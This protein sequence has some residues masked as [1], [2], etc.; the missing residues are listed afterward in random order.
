[1]RDRT[2][3]P[4]GGEWEPIKISSE[5]DPS[6]YI[7]KI[8]TNPQT[9]SISTVLL[10]TAIGTKNTHTVTPENTN[11]SSIEK[12]SNRISLVQTCKRKSKQNDQKTKYLKYSIEGVSPHINNS[13]TTWK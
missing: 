7:P 12:S 10:R 1:M 5:I 13:Y 3:R 2:R 11:R 9:V 4:E 8:T 6:A